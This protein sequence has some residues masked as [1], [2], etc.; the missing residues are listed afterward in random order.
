MPPHQPFHVERTIVSFS[1]KLTSLINN[2]RD[3]KKCTYFRPCPNEEFL[4]LE[5][6]MAGCYSRVLY[7]VQTKQVCCCRVL[8]RSAI[9]GRHLS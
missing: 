2:V 7:P 4:A 9:A 3:H 5:G 1:Y 6:V 8:Q